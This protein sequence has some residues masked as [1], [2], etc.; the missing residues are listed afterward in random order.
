MSDAARV[1]LSTRQKP[2]GTIP[3]SA[4][5]SIT[6]PRSRLRKNA[7]SAETKSAPKVISAN[8][9]RESQTSSLSRRASTASINSGR[10]QATIVT[11]T[12]IA[13]ASAMPAA[14]RLREVRSQAHAARSAKAGAAGIDADACLSPT[15]NADRRLS[16][17]QQTGRASAKTSSLGRMIFRVVKTS[18]GRM[19]NNAGNHQAGSKVR[20]RQ[21]AVGQTPALKHWEENPGN[22]V[23]AQTNQ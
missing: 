14:R 1:S 13:R 21:R 17:S 15:I 4:R 10:N 3:A 23:F 7:A 22:C 11:R 20:N 2:A 12:P 8:G 16:A 18:A 5:T 19:R 9:R 6:S